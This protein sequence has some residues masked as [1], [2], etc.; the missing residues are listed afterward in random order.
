[1]KKT[2]FI[3]IGLMVMFLSF[4]SAFADPS[5][6]IVVRASDNSLWKS[7]CAGSVCSGFTSFPGMFGSQPAVTWDEDLA[8]WVLVG[9]AADGSIW[10]STFSRAGSFNNDWAAIPGNTP[11]PPAVAGG[12]TF[13][14]FN[15]INGSNSPVTLSNTTSNIINISSTAPYAG[16]Y[17]CN[18]TGVI[19]HNRTSTSGL[20]FA[21]IYLTQTTGGTYTSWAY[22][23]VPNGTPVGVTSF[24]FAIQR[25]FTVA[26]GSNTFYMTGECNT[27][28]TTTTSATYT[29]FVCQYFPYA[30]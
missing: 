19:S 30:Y 11:S 25:W 29:G 8:S 14:N 24:P 16:F 7:T 1:M 20:D 15:A 21:R 13:S 28:A 18:G 17:A 26:A 3:F 27:S 5:S 2:A 10:R 22:T 4:S 12:G 6:L 23:D 9:R